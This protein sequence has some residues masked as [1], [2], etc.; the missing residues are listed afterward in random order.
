VADT[1]T[2]ELKIPSEPGFEKM[3]MRLAVEAA[4]RMGFTRDRVEDLRTAVSEACLNAMRHGNLL[5]ETT[6]VLVM[7]TM[8]KSKL[9]IDVQD[10]GRGGPPPAAVEAPDIEKQVAGL[11]SPGGLGLFV[12]KHLVDEAG[13]VETEGGAGNHFR[14]VIYLE[15]QKEEPC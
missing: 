8:A 3:A 12:I 5:D 7:L 6:K 9:A 15:P 4:E 10:E 11:Q 1:R 13:F 14:M 2:I